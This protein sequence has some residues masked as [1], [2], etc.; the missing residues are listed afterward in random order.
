LLHEL[1]IVTANGRE[2][3]SQYQTP[4]VVAKFTG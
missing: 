3:T 2:N 1:E 4:L